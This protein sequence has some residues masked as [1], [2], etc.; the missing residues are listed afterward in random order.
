[1]PELAKRS[2]VSW[3]TEQCR[4]MPREKGEKDGK[5]S[6]K[7]F[8]SVR[9][10]PKRRLPLLNAGFFVLIAVS[11]IV[12]LWRLPIG[13]ILKSLQEWLAGLGVWGPFVFVAIYVGAVLLLLPGSALTMAAGALFGLIWGTLVV[14]LAATT[15]AAL[16]F[17]IA[18]G[19]GREWL[20]RKMRHSP[21]F[22]ALDRAIGEGGWKIVALLR[23]S[24]AVPFN[25]QNY[26]YGLTRIRFWP[27][28]LTSAWAML[29]GILLYVYLGYLGR[30]GIEAASG[31][32]ARSPAEWTLL[33]VGLVATAAVTFY[34]ARLARKTLRQL[35]PTWSNDPRQGR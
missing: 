2:G 17:L 31:E 22:T 26:I 28:V 9:A 1:M 27:Y 14:L 13:F 35:E 12:L 15:A 33:V 16:G 5:F 20:I 18:R 11:L 6:S 30:A 29:P 34:I 21:R 19:V 10:S 32:H 8:E 3:Q 4:T 23:L 24:P 7:R 25:V